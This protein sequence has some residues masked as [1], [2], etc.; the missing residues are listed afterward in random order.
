MPPKNKENAP[1]STPRK[2]MHKTRSKPQPPPEFQPNQELMSTDES[3]ALMEVKQTLGSLTTALVMMATKVEQLS[4]GK[5]SQVA[6]WSAQPRTRAWGN[7]PAI[8][9]QVVLMS[10]QLGTRAG[11]NPTATPGRWPSCQPSLGRG[12]GETPLPLLA[13]PST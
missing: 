3:T 1:S 10:A 12:L 11:G 8:S 2:G 4:Q 7:A 6:T 5:A 9:S 13:P